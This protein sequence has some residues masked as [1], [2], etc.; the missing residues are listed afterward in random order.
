MSVLELATRVSA[1]LR[2]LLATRCVRDRLWPRGAGVRHCTHA[3]VQR[4]VRYESRIAS[5]RCFFP[6]EARGMLEIGVLQACSTSTDV[7]A[8]LSCLNPHVSPRVGIVPAF[9][10]GI[11]APHANAESTLRGLGSTACCMPHA[12]LR[13][14]YSSATGRVQPSRCSLV[15]RTLFV[16]PALENAAANCVRVPLNHAA[17]HPCC[18]THG[19]SG[20]AGVAAAEHCLGRRARRELVALAVSRVAVAVSR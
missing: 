1:R 14:T 3:T 13:P 7:C 17:W 18:K 20:R 8:A 9:L 5:Y 10:A 4:A 19:Y 11:P 15:A 12:P 16:R 6:T 2:L